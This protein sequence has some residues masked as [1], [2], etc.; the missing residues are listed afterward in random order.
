MNE[1]NAEKEECL[2]GRK[3]PAAHE[4]D[5]IVATEG[6]ARDV[7]GRK[8]WEEIFKKDRDL[9]AAVLD[10]LDAL[11]VVLDSRG[12]IARFNRTCEQVTGYNY[13]EVRGRHFFD[14]F[15]VPEEIDPVRAA[16]IN[17]RDY[18]LP[19]EYENHLVTKEGSQRLIKW[20]NKVI[21][22][23][24]GAV[25]HVI[26]IGMDITESRRM[27]EELRNYHNRLESLVSQRTSKLKKANDLLRREVAEQRRAEEN[28]ASQSKILELFFLHTLSP[29]AILDRNFNFIRVNEA[30]ARADSREPWEFPGK[31]HFDL[32][33]S[34]ARAI[35]ERVVETKM[36]YEAFARPFVYAH[37]PERGIS[38]WDWTLVPVPDASGEIDMLILSLND[39]T[40]RVRAEEGLRR[41]LKESRRSRREIA[42][43]LSS[44]R[45]IL[46]FQCFSDAARIIFETCRDLIGA[47]AGYVCMEN[48]GE[49]EAVHLDPGGCPCT[50]DP[51][52]PMPIRGLREEAYRTGKVVYENNFSSSRWTVNLPEG[53]MKL[54]NVLFA[55]L[56]ISGETR[57]LL[58][59][60]NKPGGF[61]RNDIRMAS[62]FSKDAAVALYNSMLLE[63]LKYSEERFRSVVETA[64]DAIIS[65]DHKG[66][67]VFWNS[68]AEA[69][70]GHRADE[71]AGMPV[72]F[73][74]PE[75]YR[76]LYTK[77]FARMTSGE[78]SDIAGKAWEITGIK[79][80]GRE[81]PL[82]ISVSKWKSE[83]EVYYTS[84]IRDITSRKQDEEAL[85]RLASIV[86]SSEDAIISK[87]LDGIILSW[88]SGAEK[89][90]RYS[91]EEAVGRH[92]SILI[93]PGQ[94]KKVEGILDKMKRGEH[95]EHYET[96]RLRKD[97][98]QVQV[99]IMTSPLKDAKGRI[100]GVSLIARD[101]TERKRSEEALRLSEDR[102]RKIFNTSPAM[103][104][105]ISLE[106]RRFVDVNECVLINT[107]YSREEVIGK[108]AIEM[109]Q[110]LD[111]SLVW[112]RR[113]ADPEPVRNINIKYRTKWGNLRDGLVSTEILDLYGKACMLIVAMDITNQVLLEKEMVRL[114]RLNLVGQMAAGIGHEIRNPMTAVR[115]FLQLLEGKN[116]ASQYEQY[117][118]IMIDELDR[119]NSIIT[120][121][122]SLAKNK[123]FDL[124]DS[125]INLILN[126]LSPLILAIAVNSDI[127]LSMELED[128]PKMPFNENE[129]RQLILNLVRN[130]IEAMPSGGKLVLRTF[131]DGKDLVLSVQDQG[132]GIDPSVLKNIGMPFL[133]TKDNGTGL[134]LAVCYGIAA[135]HNARI[136]IETGRAGTT[137]NVRFNPKISSADAIQGETTSK[138]FYSH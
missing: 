132:T 29:L 100:T 39:V 94:G 19:N 86:E 7:T 54:D 3:S 78:Y 2:A 97:G 113:R 76:K 77:I 73:I 5:S 51:S 131:L 115:G 24:S 8:Y 106:D 136:D 4:D 35:F 60:G 36:P 72:S 128:V 123:P 75:R 1:G 91:A 28:L 105:I 32:Y 120:E 56:V 22:G 134:G 15:L 14:I 79:K 111:E 81:F 10:T 26:S 119:A 108:N 84:I 21:S 33:P 17:L 12:R 59:F 49:N 99:S 67:I 98:S 44:S 34:D 47:T 53:H 63:T 45:A 104:A 31:N 92:I 126:V 83:E 101:I 66:T 58:A 109:L 117:F 135:R 48:G 40:R 114:E 103:T 13:K 116:L 42:A 89:I 30:Y 37:S 6:I 122:L 88:N 52:L 71:A 129:I 62:A 16:F 68:A 125:N 107:G 87:S 18:S 130:G 20:S 133:T 138:G 25:E 43:L 57:G 90:Y 11:V 69:I 110:P 137:I 112:L 93:P 50:V 82:E 38:Y 95:I 124:V 74:V 70:F 27:E 9:N 85:L 127:D 96:F 102:F 23:D 118:K 55:P 41:V 65:F 46:E 121:F 61:N 80:D 64:S